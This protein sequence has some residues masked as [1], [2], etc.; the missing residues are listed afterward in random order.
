MTEIQLQ[1][2]EDNDIFAWVV[3]QIKR[4][5]LILWALGAMLLM[6]GFNFEWPAKKFAELEK[7][8][9]SN[10]AAVAGVKEQ[11]KGIDLKVDSTNAMIRAL[12][13]IGCRQDRATIEMTEINC[14]R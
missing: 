1:R 8:Q 10:E 7:G 4:W 5:Q 11:I 14:P 6:F 13:R 3:S 9:A 12:I 2:K